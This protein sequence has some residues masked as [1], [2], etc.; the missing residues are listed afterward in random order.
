MAWC[1]V[2]DGGG[3]GVGGEEGA[4]VVEC[5]H[6]E[7]VCAVVVVIDAVGEAVAEGELISEST[8]LPSTRNWIEPGS[9]S[10]LSPFLS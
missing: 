6:L 2:V 4:G 10:T 8:W 3:D 5:A 7:G 9:S 1:G